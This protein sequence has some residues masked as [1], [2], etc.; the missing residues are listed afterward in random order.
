MA[1]FHYFSLLPK[2]VR[3]QIWDGAIRDETPS[4]HW[5]SIYQSK[6]VDPATIDDSMTAKWSSTK[7]T[8]FLCG[9][10]IDFYLSAPRYRDEGEQSWSRNNPSPYME[11]SGMWTACHESRKRMLRRFNP[12]ETSSNARLTHQQIRDL[13]T[14]TRKTTATLRIQRDNGE[15]QYITLN[16]SKDL[17]CVQPMKTPM[18][19]HSNPLGR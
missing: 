2:E 19:T 7:R 6:E 1:V 4:V 12:K 13:F 17:L 8:E 9:L 18:I 10:N 15:T 16:P 14:L 11:D 5:L 3:D